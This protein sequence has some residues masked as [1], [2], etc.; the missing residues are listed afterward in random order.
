MNY[1]IGRLAELTGVSVK[2]IRFYSDEGV[3]PAPERTASGYRRYTDDHRAHLELVRT[4]RE[5]GLDLA[6]IRSLGRRPLKEVLALHLRAVETQLTALQRTRTVLRATLDRD[7][8]TDADL[9]RLHALGRLGRAE[10]AMLLDSFVDQVGGGIE[11]RHQ[12]LANMRDCMLPELPAEP[13]TAQLDAWL[14]LTTLLADDDF[15]DNLRRSSD[16]FW[17][18]PSALDAWRQTTAAMVDEIGRAGVAPD[19]PEAASVLARVLELTGQTREEW[20][21]VFDE[22]DPRAERL[23][24]LV[25]IVRGTE[26]QPPAV[27]TAYA[28]L[29]QA[30]RHSPGEPD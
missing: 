2:T 29:E 27:A 8:P 22:H 1:S 13:T 10:Q 9:R 14:E 21:R 18:E 20:L 4:M 23:W 25:A 6:T 11:A 28:W 19:S 24:R 12:W 17:A 5:I 3:L 30:L 26:Y 7:D 16:D 15:R